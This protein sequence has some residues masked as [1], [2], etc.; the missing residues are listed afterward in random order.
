MELVKLISKYDPVLRLH[1]ENFTK[2][3]LNNLNKSDGKKKE[4]NI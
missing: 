4:G 2:K 3:H 1:I